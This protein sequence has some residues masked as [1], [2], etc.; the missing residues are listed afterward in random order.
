MCGAS[1]ACFFLLT[2]A[3]ACCCARLPSVY[4]RFVSLSPLFADSSLG[5]DSQPSSSPTACPPI[6]CPPI[7]CPP[8]ECS[9]ERCSFSGCT[10]ALVGIPPAQHCQPACTALLS[11][12]FP[13]LSGYRA[14]ARF[15][16][17]V[18]PLMVTFV[19]IEREVPSWPLCDWWSASVH[20]TGGS[21]G[22]AFCISGAWHFLRHLHLRCR[23][24][25][26]PCIVAVVGCS[27]VTELVQYPRSC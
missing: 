7:E 2:S 21:G 17:C 6:E 8:N 16:R 5:C 18:M 1:F 9:C 10:L 14:S 11:L 24:R 22:L 19:S 4:V 12:S 3:N 26:S 23:L 25:S 13:V 20:R 15:H 27:L